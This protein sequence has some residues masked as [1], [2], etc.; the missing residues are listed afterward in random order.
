MLGGGA[1]GVPDPDRRP[2]RQ[3]LG[4]LVDRRQHPLGPC[5]PAIGRGQYLQHFRSAGT[6]TNRAVWHFAAPGPAGAGRG[7]LAGWALVPLDG[8]RGLGRITAPPA[9]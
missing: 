8:G 3:R 4:G 1:A 7:R 9:G 5:R 2:R 6:K